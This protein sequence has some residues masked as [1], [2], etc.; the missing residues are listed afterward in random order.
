[1]GG[2]VAGAGNGQR[3]MMWAATA[4]P[5]SHAH[6]TAAPPKLPI[7]DVCPAAT[8]TSF[9]VRPFCLEKNARALPQRWRVRQRAKTPRPPPHFWG[10]VVAYDFPCAFWLVERNTHSVVAHALQLLSSSGLTFLL[11]RGGSTE[12][13]T[14]TERPRESLCACRRRCR[15]AAPCSSLYKHTHAFVFFIKTEAYEE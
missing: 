13:E 4:A 7:L 5:N 3:E 15:S 14:E 12:R 8:Q 6:S 10:E 11:W 1:M 9:A 2:P